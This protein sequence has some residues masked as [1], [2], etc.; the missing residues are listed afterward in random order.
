MLKHLL[1]GSGSGAV[2][3]PW[4]A[5]LGGSSDDRCYSVAVAPD[6]P[7]MFVEKPSRMVLEA[8]IFFL[9]N[10]AALAPCNGRGHLVE[11]KWTLVPP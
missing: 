6:V 4:V 8:L 3:D 11:A 2:G 7:F 10:S 1:R 5:T 9:Q